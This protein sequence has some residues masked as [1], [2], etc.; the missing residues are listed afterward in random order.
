MNNIT[1]GYYEAEILEPLNGWFGESEKGSV[2]VRL[3][4]RIISPTVQGTVI[5]KGYLSS[6]KAEARTIR[7]LREALSVPNNW[8]ELL[9]Q[10][11]QF[12]IG[13]RVSATIENETGDNG[14]TY[15]TVPWINNIDRA[16]AAGGGQA[17]DKNKLAALTRRMAAM[18]KSI[19][20]EGQAGSTQASAPAPRHAEPAPRKAVR[21]SDPIEVEDDDIPF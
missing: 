1:P 15:N 5:W 17:A 6:E 9:M 7:Q 18:T 11:D 21:S 4:L 13:Q 10:G 2:F 20:A 3:A 12:L 14:K 16:G 8:F 19:A